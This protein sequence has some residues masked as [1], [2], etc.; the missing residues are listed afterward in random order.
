MSNPDILKLKINKCSE[1]V[2]VHQGTQTIPIGDR[3][4][5]F[6]YVSDDG[7]LAELDREK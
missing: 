1:W 2:V 5:R 6:S 7:N 4:Y 3:L